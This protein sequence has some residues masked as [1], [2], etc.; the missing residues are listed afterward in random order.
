[1]SRHPEVKWAQRSDKIY[2]T[3]ELPDAKNPKVK[4]EPEGKFTFSA[5]A[6]PEDVSYELDFHLFDKINVE[7]SKVSV[8]LRHV[9]CVFIKAEKKWWKRLL[10]PEGKPPPYLKADWDKWVDED[11][12]NET[13]SNKF[14]NFDLD[15]MNDFSDFNM[16]GAGMDAGDESDSDD[17]DAKVTAKEST[18]GK[19]EGGEEIKTEVSEK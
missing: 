1:M 11:D 7:E 18:E 8:G 2:L 10:S 13:S 9:F 12:E 16:G 6:G 3:V 5:T 15:S 17:E 19:V 14:D 4:I